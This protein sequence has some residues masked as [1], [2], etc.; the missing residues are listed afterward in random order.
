MVLSGS[1][2]LINGVGLFVVVVV[3][4]EAVR[5]GGQPAMALG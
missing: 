3:G 2:V 5:C 1:A 4:E